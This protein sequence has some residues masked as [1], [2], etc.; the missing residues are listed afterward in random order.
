MK[1]INTLLK[2]YQEII[3]YVLFGGFTTVVNLAVFWLLNK[4]IGEN[5]YLINNIIAWFAAVVFAYITNKLWVFESKS[6]ALKIV[7]KEIP[8]FFLARVFSLAVEEGGLWL[9]VEIMEFDKLSFDLLGFAFT[10]KLIAKI[11]LAVIVVILN[12]IFSKFIIFAKKKNE[13]N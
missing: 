10:G 3:L 5:A 11:L 4:A 2:K 9:F 13:S 6:W 8:E 7:I 1:K 12:Y